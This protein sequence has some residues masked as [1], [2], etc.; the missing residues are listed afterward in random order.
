MWTTGN[1]NEVMTARQMLN[2]RVRFFLKELCLLWFYE[3]L[4]CADKK[5][6]FN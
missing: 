4:I 1:P 3:P 6:G 5:R 2:A